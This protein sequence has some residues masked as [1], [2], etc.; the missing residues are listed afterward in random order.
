MVRVRKVKMRKIILK[1][2]IIFVFSLAYAK[3]EAPDFRLKNLAGE[4]VILSSYRGQKPVVLIFWNTRC[5]FCIR[6]LLWLNERYPRFIQDDCKLIAVNIGESISK[7]KNFLKKIPLDFEIV[8]DPDLEV[9]EE[10]NLF[11]VPT[12]IFIDRDGYLMFRGYNFN[13]D[14]YDKLIS[15]NK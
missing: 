7:V 10:Y 12:Y 8:L 9:A 6:E 14:K 2:L 13:L 3:T 4:E 1:V 5:P 11:G 15:P